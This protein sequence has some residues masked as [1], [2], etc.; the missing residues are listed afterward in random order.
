MLFTDLRYHHFTPEHCGEDLQ[1]AIDKW[2]NDEQ[3]Q[4]T[5]KITP[6]LCLYI[7]SSE[8][9]SADFWYESK[10]KHPNRS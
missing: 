3:E 4:T 9:Y 2:I 8:G 7:F 1:V 10:K 5:S 6:A